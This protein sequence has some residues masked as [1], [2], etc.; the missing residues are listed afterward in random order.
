MYEAGE[1]LACVLPADVVEHLERLVAEVDDVAGVEVDPVGRRGDHHIGN[2][3][4]GYAEADRRVKAAL[5][6]LGRHGPR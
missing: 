4:G 3:R 5:G 1:H 6:A 2:L